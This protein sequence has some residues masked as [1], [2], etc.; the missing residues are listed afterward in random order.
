[1]GMAPIIDG[2]GLIITIFSY[3]GQVTVSPTSDVKTMP[4]INVFTRYIRESAN[5]LEAAILEFDKQRKQEDEQEIPDHA[6]SDD[7]F[8]YLKKY[9]KDHPE[10]LDNQTGLYQ[11]KVTG[12]APTDWRLD[13]EKPA[14]GIRKGRVRSPFATFTMEDEHL[15]KVAKGEIDIPTAFVQ[16]RLKVEGDMS[17]AMKLG[18]LL[19]K[20]PPMAE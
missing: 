16:G 2:M 15:L 10:I 18:K 17:Q 7:F 1:M 11:F 5:E 12:L 14:G 3:N 6:A 13:L 20:V 8:K 19:S 4:D 9:L